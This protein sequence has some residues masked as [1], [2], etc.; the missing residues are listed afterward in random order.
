MGEVDYAKW[1]NIYDNNINIEV[2][3]H[4]SRDQASILIKYSIYIHNEQ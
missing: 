4:N 3:K 2:N 1:S